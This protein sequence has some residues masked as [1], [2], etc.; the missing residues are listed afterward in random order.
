MPETWD[1]RRLMAGAQAA[2]SHE[3][4]DPDPKIISQRLDPDL[5]LR[6]KILQPRMP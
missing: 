3:V 2:E 1:A 4:A 5:G 6:E